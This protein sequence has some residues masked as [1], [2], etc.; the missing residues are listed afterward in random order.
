[1]QRVGTVRA[2]EDTCNA[3]IFDLDGTLIDSAPSILASYQAVLRQHRVLP[4]EPLGPH[5]IGPP[6]L[7]TLAR[8]TGVQDPVRLARWADAFK[9]HYDAEGYRA[10]AVYGGVQEALQQLRTSGPA[11]Y[12][13]TNKRI[14]AARLIL[15]HLGWAHWFAGVYAQ[16]AF[17]P[18]LPSKAAV[19][20]RVLHQ[21]GIAPQ[22]AWYVGDRSEDAQAAAAN[23]L[24]FA[25][26]RWGYDPG[27]DLSI[28]PEA[29]ALDAPQ[30]LLCLT[31]APSM[32]A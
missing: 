3:L 23:G 10:S 32:G 7:P 9:A 30:H 4:R 25:W 13:V 22:Q 17:A 24:R 14:H 27:L 5:L 29:K 12:I 31:I 6:L 15:Q 11:L 28:W 20:E 19:L 16:D 2:R 18:A 21:H 1:L 26:A 8:I